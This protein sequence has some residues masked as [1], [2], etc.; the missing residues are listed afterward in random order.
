M[1]FDS[2]TLHWQEN[3]S[4]KKTPHKGLSLFANKAFKRGNAIFLIGG[5]IV[6][7]WE[8]TKYT[9]PISFDLAI[10]PVAVDN[11]AKYLCHSCEPTAG[12]HQRTV[13]VALRDISVGE[14]V[15]IDYAMIVDQYDEY[16]GKIITREDIICRCEAP[17]CR[18]EFGSY[19]KLTPELKEKYQGFISDYLIR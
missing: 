9:V 1:K 13:V 12:I 4:V 3:I 2:L 19:N 7:K 8:R 16:I 17:T 10:D 18:G 15:A 5:P 6:T 11:V 14:E